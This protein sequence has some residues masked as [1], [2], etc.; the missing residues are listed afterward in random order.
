VVTGRQTGPDGGDHYSTRVSVAQAGIWLLVWQEDENIVYYGGCRGSTI[1]L[2]AYNWDGNSEF[3][4]AGYEF[5]RGEDFEQDESTTP[6]IR[7]SWVDTSR[8]G[9]TVWTHP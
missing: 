2:D 3:Q 7:A 4:F 1:E 9:T 5:G 8:A 6:I